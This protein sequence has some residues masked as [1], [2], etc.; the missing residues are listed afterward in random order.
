MYY[1]IFY[2]IGVIIFLI[3]IILEMRTI[4]DVTLSD[5]FMAFFVSLI[6][7]IGIIFWIFLFLR[8]K[9]DD[10]IVIKKKNQNGEMNKLKRIV[11]NLLKKYGKYN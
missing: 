6:S 7:W 1:F 2:I 10:I 4:R 11:L 8:N 3:W 5:I 9:S